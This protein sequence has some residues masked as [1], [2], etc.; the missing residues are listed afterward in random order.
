MTPTAALRSER[1]SSIAVVDEGGERVRGAMQAAPRKSMR[2]VGGVR[3]MRVQGDAGLKRGRC[4][5]FHG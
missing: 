2:N 5:L 3:R 4:R 1:A